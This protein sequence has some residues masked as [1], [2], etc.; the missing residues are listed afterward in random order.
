MY[1]V[2]ENQLNFTICALEERAYL[3][4][5]SVATLVATTTV[6]ALVGQKEKNKQTKHQ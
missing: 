5:F 1:C 4:N 6:A 3:S 2:P